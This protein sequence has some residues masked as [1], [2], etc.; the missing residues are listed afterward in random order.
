[1]AKKGIARNRRKLV[2]TFGLVCQGCIEDFPNHE[3]TVDHIRPLAKGGHPRALGNLQLL[4]NPCNNAK[5]DSWD[6]V[7]GLGL[8]DCN[9]KKMSVPQQAQRCL[10]IAGEAVA[11]AGHGRALPDLVTIGVAAA[12]GAIP[13]GY[14][15]HQELAAEIRMHKSDPRIPIQRNR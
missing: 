4:C 6:G 12:I 14:A 10:Q 8:D 1:M 11:S 3:L 7:S 15:A 5:G 13:S 9:T 2:A